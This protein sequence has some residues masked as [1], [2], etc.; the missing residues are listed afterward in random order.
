M[1]DYFVHGKLTKTYPIECYKSAIKNLPG[2]IRGYSDARDV[3]ESAM[4]AAIANRKHP[5]KKGGS[6]PAYKRPPSGP[7]SGS[8]NGNG[9][10]NGGGPSATP[11]TAT[12]PAPGKSALSSLISKLGPKNASS[13]PLPLL[14]LAG[15]ALLL[16]AAAGSSVIAKKVQARRLAHPAPPPEDVL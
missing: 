8:S 16:L 5:G 15:I 14:I 3:I 6:L 12:P 10:G 13:V 1:N 9:N 7:G 11:A 4:L 2:D